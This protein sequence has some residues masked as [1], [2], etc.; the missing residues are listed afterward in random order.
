VVI[1]STYGKGVV[2][3]N[4]ENQI[5]EAT[6]LTEDQRKEQDHWI[7]WLAKQ[8]EARER[9]F[10]YVAANEALTRSFFWTKWRSSSLDRSALLKR[11]S[12]ISSVFRNCSRNLKGAA[13]ALLFFLSVNFSFC[14]ASA[15]CAEGSAAASVPWRLTLA[16]VSSPSCTCGFN[17]RA[18]CSH[19]LAFAVTWAPSPYLL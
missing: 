3:E 6:V 5:M 1:L 8:R 2:D 11:S 13:T 12:I 17:A 9:D 18:D 4:H 7:A 14:A 19:E 15:A 16:S 10:C